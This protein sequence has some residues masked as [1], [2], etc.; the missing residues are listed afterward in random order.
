MNSIIRLFNLCFVF[1]LLS[2][3]Y[4]PAHAEGMGVSPI[5]DA[6][7]DRAGDGWEGFGQAVADA[8]FVGPMP[9]RSYNVTGE[10]AAPVTSTAQ[11]GG[12]VAICSGCH[13]ALIGG[14]SSS[15]PFEVGWRA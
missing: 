14:G 9:E 10:N 1:A 12:Q 7:E 8:D 2:C 13:I 4:A 5:S 15:G 11:T 6:W 3:A